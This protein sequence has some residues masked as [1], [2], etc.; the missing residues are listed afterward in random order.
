MYLVIIAIAIPVS[1]VVNGLINFLF[2]VYEQ[3]SKIARNNNDNSVTFTMPDPYSDEAI[4]LRRAQYLREHEQ[5]VVIDVNNSNDCKPSN[6]C[7]ERGEIGCTGAPTADLLTRTDK[8][9]GCI[10]TN[11]INSNVSSIVISL[12]NGTEFE[13]NS[14]GAITRVTNIEIVP[15]GIITNMTVEP[16]SFWTNGTVYHTYGNG[17]TVNTSGNSKINLTDFNNWCSERSTIF[18]IE[19]GCGISDYNGEPIIKDQGIPN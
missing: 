11:E 4:N 16:N 17:T 5:K 1:I 2:A 6:M 7:G 18:L 12:S 10:P 15:N 13:V 3:E 19:R 14:S 8:E 9:L